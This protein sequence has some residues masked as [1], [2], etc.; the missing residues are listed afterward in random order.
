MFTL[1]LFMNHIH[2]TDTQ[3]IFSS[4]TTSCHFKNKIYKYIF[5]KIYKRQ[6][7]KFLH[8]YIFHY[9]KQFYSSSY[10]HTPLSSLMFHK[11]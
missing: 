4:Q 9:L 7:Y 10:N 11:S 1:F 8:I 3:P 5:I 6:I 2:P